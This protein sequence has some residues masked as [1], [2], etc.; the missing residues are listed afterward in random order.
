MEQRPWHAHYPEG[1]PREIDPDRFSSLA[2]L[3][4]ASCR[5]YRERRAF[6]NQGHTLSFADI[7]AA[8]RDFAAYLV[9][10][11]HL[12][13]GDRVAVMLPNLLQSPIVMLGILRAGLTVVNVNPL[14]TVRELEHQ[15]KDSGARAIVVLENF[16]A[17]L[18]KALP[19]TDIS[20]VIVT[21]IGDCLPAVKRVLTNFVVRHIK[22][23]VPSYRLE[24]SV[25]WREALRHGQALD[26]G[27]PEIAPEDVAFLQYTGGTT[28]VA[29]GAMLSHRNVVAN[30]LQTSAWVG[31]ALEPKDDTAVTPLPLYHIYALTVNLFTF[32]HLGAH[33]LLIT[34]P[35][36]FKRF[37][38]DLRANEFAFITGVNTLF[39]ALTRAPG[40][41]RIDFSGLKIVMGGGMA[42]HADVAERW[43]RMT[44]VV[45][46]QGYG[47]TEASPV[48]CANPLDIKRFDGSV[49]LPFPSTDVMLID[50]DGQPAAERGELCVKGPQVMQGYWQRQDETAAAFLDGGWLKTGDIARIDGDGRLYIEDRKKDVIIVS[51]FNVYPSEV[52]DVVASHPGVV[53]AAA[54]GIPSEESGEAVKVYVVKHDESLDA[55]E[56]MAYC[57]ERLTGYKS[58]DE[59]EFVAELPKSNVGKVLRRELKQ[60][61][62][63]G[64]SRSS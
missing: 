27:D 39:N 54:I 38:R 19:K 30:V 7:D 15:L 51:G 60:W 28:G 23:I 61:H 52:E 57:R 3:C 45:I 43:Q 1:V 6:S 31:G 14:Y 33:N 44:G 56:L 63:K 58:P 46:N 40:F 2:E 10:G 47:L 34:N 26:Y 41:D 37:V 64:L 13:R 49:G 53:E 32:W 8:S 17:T 12:E 48:V 35:R 55:A 5:E 24:Q 29:K 25:R 11:A 42:V 36:D 16:G 20:T 4:L 18:E 59:V 62:E 50:D 9:A 21:A 22:R